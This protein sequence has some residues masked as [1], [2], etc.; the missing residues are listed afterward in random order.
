M[1]DRP[2]LTDEQLQRLATDAPLMAQVK[3]QLNSDELRRL[4]KV[5]SPVPASGVNWE[6]APTFGAMVGGIGGGLLG[7]PPGALGGAALGGA[8]GKGAANYMTGG[9]TNAGD[10][11]LQA[12]VEGGKQ[13]I[14]ELPG[15]ALSAVSRPAARR[16]M[17]S[18]L[19]PSNELVKS[20][21]NL[22]P[23][24]R[25]KGDA[26]ERVLAASNRDV[27]GRRVGF[28]LA[29]TRASIEKVQGAIDGINDS[30]QRVLDAAGR[31]PGGM[32]V[33]IR[34]ALAGPYNELAQKTMLQGHPGD[35]LAV[36]NQKYGAALEHPLAINGELFPADAQRIK[37]GTYATLRKKYGEMGDAAVQSEKATARGY[38]QDIANVAPEVAALNLGES[39]LIF[40]E[41]AL[42]GANN[43]VG[44]NDPFG[45][46][47]AA[48]TTKRFWM[49]LADRSPVVKS[50]L[51][52]VIRATGP[53]VGLV[54]PGAT[55]A[56][57]LGTQQ[58]E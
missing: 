33:N 5:A 38:K 17:Q 27:T 55:R 25:T 13:A 4:S 34:R 15:V 2:S 32:R 54:A 8:M 50:Y 26:A 23:P 9:A 3:S 10:A 57:V 29:P 31:G 48:P 44:N 18:A 28:P 20:G 52:R 40:V 1:P 41:K 21:S 43:R 11:V 46:A 58:P 49:A 47:N 36:V 12:V 56:M 45:F 19:K 37:T 6:M 39:E 24:V 14:W 16:L 30:I 53:T 35:D 42:Q 22:Q 51:A 7:G